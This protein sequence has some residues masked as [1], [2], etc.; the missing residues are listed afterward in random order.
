MLRIF[1]GLPAYLSSAKMFR[2]RLP[3][4]RRK[5][6]SA[7]LE[8]V[9]AATA[10]C[11]RPFGRA[12]IDNDGVNEGEPTRPPFLYSMPVIKKLEQSNVRRNF[13]HEH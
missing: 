12:A 5:E 2:A 9:E 6:P 1:H 4:K 13:F 11:M 8:I 7:E 10:L 3:T